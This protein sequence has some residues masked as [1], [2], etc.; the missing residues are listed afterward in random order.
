MPEYT[1]LEVVMRKILIFL[2]LFFLLIALNSCARELD[3]TELLSE[4]VYT[5]G[6]EGVIYSPHVS[7]GSDGFVYE[8]LTERIFV[9]DGEF[10]ENY[11]V[12][13]NSRAGYGGECGVFVCEDADEWEMVSDIC[14][15]RVALLSGGEGGLIIRS[16]GVIFY[17]TLKDNERAEDIWYKIMR[18]HT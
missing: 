14:R 6:A 11:A 12:L 10:P 8:G 15:E 18:A 3:A 1:L 13:L 9:Y 17:S 5:Y 16:R 4:F 7:E 2:T